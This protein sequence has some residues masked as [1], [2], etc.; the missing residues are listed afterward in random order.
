VLGHTS[1]SAGIWRLRR[2]LSPLLQSN[3]NSGSFL[4]GLL[5]LSLDGKHRE[6]PGEPLRYFQVKK[7]LHR[8]IVTLKQRLEGGTCHSSAMGPWIGKLA[9][10]GR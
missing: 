4:K 7:S 1:S 9:G 8:D 3:K 2:G 5:H 6:G 10:V